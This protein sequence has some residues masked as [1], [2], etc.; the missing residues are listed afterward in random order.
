MRIT[1]DTAKIWGATP[2]DSIP[3]G[4]MHPTSNKYVGLARQSSDPSR[5]RTTLV[6]LARAQIHYKHEQRWSGSRELRSI[7]SMSNVGLTRE[8]SDPSRSGITWC[9]NAYKAP[10]GCQQYDKQIR[11]DRPPTNFKS[12]P[13][14]QQ[15]CLRVMTPSHDAILIS[16]IMTLE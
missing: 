10:R 6:W 1:N 4:W 11:R 15:V 5:A 13:T 3:G 9:V 8:S 12:M 16:K 14:Q 7:T 2:L